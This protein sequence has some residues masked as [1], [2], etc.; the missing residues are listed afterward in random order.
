MTRARD[1]AFEALAE[2]TGSDWNIARGELNASLTSIS[3]QEPQLG[4]K[5]MS[6]A[7]EIHRRAK[8]Y[9]TVMPEVLL[10]PTALAKHWRR[11]DIEAEQIAA[12]ATKQQTNRHASVDCQTCGG[13]R[14]VHVSSRKSKRTAWMETKG[15]EPND[16]H[17]VEEYASCPDCNASCATSFRRYSGTMAVPPDPARVREMMHG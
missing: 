3:L 15:I 2:V 16:Q 17:L 12:R 7:D 6:L 14:F 11:I 10:T 4:P 9:R 8:L 5:T 1:Y 13:D